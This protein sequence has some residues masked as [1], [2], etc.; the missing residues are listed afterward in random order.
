VRVRHA[1]SADLRFDG[2]IVHRIDTDRELRDVLD[3]IEHAIDEASADA[4]A[5]AWRGSG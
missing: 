1:I 5:G 4:E 3:E 2:T